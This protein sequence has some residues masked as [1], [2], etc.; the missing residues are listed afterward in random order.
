MENIV[1]VIKDYDDFFRREAERIA[2]ELPQVGLTINVI[3]GPYRDCDVDVTNSKSNPKNITLDYYSAIRA[4]F[5]Q[6]WHDEVV[7]LILSHIEEH[8]IV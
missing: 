2:T 3:S 5:G 6:L 8:K 4:G 7:K 1:I